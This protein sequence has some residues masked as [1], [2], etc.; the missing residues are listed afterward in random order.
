M[1]KKQQKYFKSFFYF[2]FILCK[3]KQNI[4]WV[5]NISF[6]K[7]L[8]ASYSL[9]LCKIK[10]HAQIDCISVFYTLRK[11]TQA[12]LL[13]I[14]SVPICGHGFSCILLLFF[15]ISLLPSRLLYQ[16]QQWQGYLLQCIKKCG[17]VY[18]FFQSKC[19]QIF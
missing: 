10:P 3:T 11:E 15:K 17:R 9:K 13:K 19:G 8:K 1:A 4:P 7:H 5:Q 14:R 6:Y 2:V 18:R 16:F 12:L